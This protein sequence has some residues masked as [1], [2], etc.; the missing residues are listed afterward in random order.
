MISVTIIV[1]IINTI[2]I[3]EGKKIVFVRFF[4]AALLH[5]KHFNTFVT[6]A[7]T[8]TL[9]TAA[10]EVNELK[11]LDDTQHNIR[12]QVFKTP[13]YITLYR[14]LDTYKIHCIIQ[15]NVFSSGCLKGG[16]SH[17]YMFS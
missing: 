16:H 9:S 14:L 17:F 1:V 11:S 8:S 5:L 3:N 4:S 10:D 15:F 13:S 6:G 12:R 2:I 7:G